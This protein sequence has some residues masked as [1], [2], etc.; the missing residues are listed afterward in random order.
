MNT[1][2]KIGGFLHL[3]LNPE[4]LRKLTENYVVSNAKIKKAIG[5]EKMHVKATEGLEKTIMSFK[6]K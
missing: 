5:V 6:N 2:A 1:F 4:R 3:P